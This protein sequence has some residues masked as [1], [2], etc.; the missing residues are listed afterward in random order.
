VITPTRVGYAA[1]RKLDAPSLSMGKDFS[2][3]DYK[4][5]KVVLERKD[6]KFLGGVSLNEHTSLQYGGDT[7]AVNRFV[8]ALSSCPNVTVRVLFFRPGPSGI[9]SDWIVTQEANLHELVV[10]INLASKM[11]KME[12]LYLPPVRAENSSEPIGTAT[13]K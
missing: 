9:A 10:R 5:V 2:D 7:T 6:C 3:A 13:Q 12:N 4:R 8:E 11:V 1:Y